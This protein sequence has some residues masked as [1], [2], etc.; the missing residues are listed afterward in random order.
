MINGISVP[1]EQR[2][3]LLEGL[4]VLVG[5]SAVAS[6][7]LVPEAGLLV[8]IGCAALWF[9]AVV[10]DVFEG[11]VEGLVLCWAAFFPLGYLIFLFPPVHPI[12]TAQRLVVLSAFTGLFFAKPNMLLAIPRPLRRAALI[13][14]AFIAVAAVCISSIICA[15]IAAA[16]MV[17]GEDLLPYDG[18]AM[19]YAGGIPRPN[20]PFGSNDALA[21]VGALSFF[22]LL[23]FRAA[24]STSLGAGRRMLHTIGVAAA[25]GMALMPMFRS[26]VITL[27]LAL[28]IDAFCEKRTTRRAWHVVLILAFLGLIFSVSVF[29]P[30]M[31][32]DRSDSQNVY[33]RVA[34]Y[35]QSLRVFVDH[36]L[37]GVGFS[38]FI[39][40]VAGM[41]P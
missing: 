1:A 23:F 22:F 10:C 19:F 33:A 17:T 37:L 28:I 11:K 26:I 2:T 31:F 13:C 4:L 38:S 16:E 27:L 18:S 36:P 20:G 14:L 24:L 12:I 6:L 15:A 8:V 9:I 40:F 30:D 39:A 7:I 32:A 41:R 29:A 21:M 35:E 25:L 34:Q 3:R 5:A